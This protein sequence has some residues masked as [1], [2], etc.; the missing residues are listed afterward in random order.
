MTITVLA[1]PL[2]GTLI[3]TGQNELFQGSRNVDR[4][5]GNGG[6]DLLNGNEGNDSLFGGDGD[7]ELYGGS[8]TLTF[9]ND[10]NDYL[11]GGNGNDWLSG[12]TGLD[13]LLGSTGNDRLF[14]GTGNDYLDGGNQNDYLAGEDGLD[15]LLGGSSFDV[16]VGG[17][18][19]DTLTGGSENDWFAYTAL[20]QGGDKIT[21]FTMG[22]DQVLLKASDFGLNKLLAN[23][24]P[25]N[26]TLANIFLTSQGLA[27]STPFYRVD[28]AQ[29]GIFQTLALAQASGKSLAIVS[30]AYGSGTPSTTP[31][32]LYQITGGTETLIA[33]FTNGVIPGQTSLND[34]LLY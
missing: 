10:G 3:G 28:I 6:N 23:Q 4:I 24:V 15:R 27:S 18:G 26:G 32:A 9:I 17:L 16:L 11:D 8:Q 31:A 5:L 1:N 30:A 25:V 13:T 22:I 14:G 19:S 34:F 21:D 20:N 2:G 33:E 29:F 12:G 7:D